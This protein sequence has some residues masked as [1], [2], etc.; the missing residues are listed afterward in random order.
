[1]RRP[2]LFVVALLCTACV[3]K[4]DLEE[5]L[6]PL[7][8][9]TIVLQNDQQELQ[10]RVAATEVRTESLQDQLS[11]LPQAGTSP[12]A[13][14]KSASG[15]KASTGARPSGQSATPP[16]APATPPAAHRSPEGPAAATETVPAPATAATESSPVR[17]AP[18]VEAMTPPA[19][20]TASPRPAQTERPAYQ[21][22]LKMYERGRYTEAEALFDAFIKDFPNSKLMPNALYWKGECQYARGGY[23]D[24]IF[25]FKDVTARF[26]GHPKAAD[27]LFKTALAY[28][29]L[30]DQENAQLHFRVL[31]E[32]YPSSPLLRRGKAL[33]LQP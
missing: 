5:R 11:A 9:Q 21:N 24:A 3:G 15:K 17:N 1:M 20:P 2:I 14:S 16:A 28:K 32:D 33:G 31:S 26:P 25:V 19:S 7:E 4:N 13:K 18:H 22:A 23:A 10:L 8:Q 27:A 12:V 6:Q 29:N 30:G